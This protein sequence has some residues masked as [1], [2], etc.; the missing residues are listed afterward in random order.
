MEPGARPAFL[1]WLGPCWFQI[2]ARRLL[3]A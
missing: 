2:R 3:D 1:A